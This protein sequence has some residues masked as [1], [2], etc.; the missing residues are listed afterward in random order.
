M[1][2]FVFRRAGFLLI[3][4]Q[5]GVGMERLVAGW[6][7]MPSFIVITACHSYLLAALC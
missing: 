4:I 3:A 6:L 7:C 5:R 1:E 2:A